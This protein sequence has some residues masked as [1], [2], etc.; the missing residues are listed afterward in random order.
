MNLSK[1]EF[2]DRTGMRAA[3]SA[4]LFSS[5]K[6]ERNGEQGA[7]YSPNFMPLVSLLTVASLSAS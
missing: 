5:V 6:F 2:F 4:R 1:N 7:D 3:N